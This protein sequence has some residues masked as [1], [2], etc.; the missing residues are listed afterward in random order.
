[1]TIRIYLRCSTDDQNVKSQR[2]EL[3]KWARGQDEGVVW[4]KE[5][6]DVQEGVSGMG[7]GRCKDSQPV[8][9]PAE[10]RITASIFRRDRS[11]T[12]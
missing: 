3:V 2:H 12:F 4:Y 6:V 1:M 8:K 11:T 9:R 7:A 10:T 5:T